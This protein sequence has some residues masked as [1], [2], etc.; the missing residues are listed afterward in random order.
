MSEKQHEG[1]Y[2]RSQNFWLGGA[3]SGKI[4]WR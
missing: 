3:Q 1:L 4:L 2:W